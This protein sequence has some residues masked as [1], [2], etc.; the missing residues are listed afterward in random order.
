MT[1]TEDGV[2][3]PERGSFTFAQSMKAKQPEEVNVYMI[4]YKR[5][6]ALRTQ[7]K[8]LG[9]PT[10]GFSS[11]KWAFVGIAATAAASLL[12]WWPAF[13]AMD[14]E[15]RG[16]FTWVWVVLF[17]ALVLGVGV[18][19]ALFLADRKIQ[20]GRGASVAAVLKEMDMLADQ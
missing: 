14:G 19:C 7:I 13:A 9:Q 16:G 11:A 3:A 6:D 20:E 2:V 8:E 5:W 15:M 12:T 1:T 4:P 10:T 17:S 18:A